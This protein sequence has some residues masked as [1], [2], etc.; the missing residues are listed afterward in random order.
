VV[1][2]EN[3]AVEMDIMTADDELLIVLLFQGGRI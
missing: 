2:G 1:H 3:G